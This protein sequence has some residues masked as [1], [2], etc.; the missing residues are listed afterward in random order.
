MSLPIRSTVRHVLR[1]SARPRTYRQ[2][3][4]GCRSFLNLFGKSKVTHSEDDLFFPFSHSPFPAVRA[5]GDAVRSL[6]RCPVCSTNGHTQKVNPSLVKYECP[7]CGWPSHCSKEHWEIDEEHKKYC[8]R[9]RQVNEDEHDLRS[10]RK[11]HEFQLPGANRKV[12]RVVSGLTCRTGPQ[13]YEEA[14]S[15]ANWDLFWYTRGFPSMD[16]ERSRRHAS[17][18]LTY[19]LT[20][21]SVLHQNSGLT[22]NNQR[23]TLE[24]SRSLAGRTF[25]FLYFSC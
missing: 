16:T 21:G 17:K 9:L 15:F 13:A 5:R 14:I 25:P 10:G 1:Y 11:M 20:I 4:G 8:S 22:L 6:A 3:V 12:Q 23:V 19:P 7:D 24:G 2:S 18:L